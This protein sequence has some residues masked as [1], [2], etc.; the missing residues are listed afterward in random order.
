MLLLAATLAPSQPSPMSQPLTYERAI[1]SLEDLA[2]DWT[3]S[4]GVSLSVKSD[5]RDRKVTCCFTQKPLKEVMG[6][7]AET[8]WMQWVP[9]GKGFRLELTSQ[10]KRLEQEG[11]KEAE[12]D[13]CRALTAVITNLVQMGK[14]PSLVQQDPFTF[15]EEAAYLSRLKDPAARQVVE[16]LCVNGKKLL[17]TVLKGESV[18]VMAKPSGEKVALTLNQLINRKV[19]PGEQLIGGLLHE[20]RSHEWIIYSYRLPN[21]KHSFPDREVRIPLID[22]RTAAPTRLETAISEWAGS[23]PANLKL[24]QLSPP[25]RR[26]YPGYSAEAYG[27]GDHLIDLGHRSRHPIIADAYRRAISVD[28][29]Y[30]SST[31]GEFMSKLGVNNSKQQPYPRLA[32]R[33]SD[34]WLLFR[35]RDPLP[36]IDQEIPERLLLPI[37]SKAR[38]EQ[39]ISLEEMSQFAVQLTPAQVDGILADDYAPLVRFSATRFRAGL[40]FFR[41]YARLTPKQKIALRTKGQMIDDSYPANQRDLVASLYTKGIWTANMARDISSAQGIYT[42]PSRIVLAFRNATPNMF[43][44]N[45]DDRY[46]IRNTSKNAVPQIDANVAAVLYHGFSQET[47]LDGLV[48]P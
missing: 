20:T 46:S 2:K 12:A 40:P 14:P 31:I 27:L 11:R 35:S 36:K 1:V 18:W 29:W 33:T 23:I 10:A 25:S 39:G 47:V 45:L 9:E 43:S 22:D 24:Q 48:K 13:R 28:S 19:T 16:G 7:L 26:A 30:E 21:P 15:T 32:V 4:T 34:D 6:K 38:T 5:I 42:R 37:E 41:L 8:M 3:R 17:A 44:S